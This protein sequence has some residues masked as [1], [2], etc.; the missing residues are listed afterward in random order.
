MKMMGPCG[1]LKVPRP[2]PL[3]LH[4][5]REPLKLEQPQHVFFI[6]FRR[7]NKLVIGDEDVEQKSLSNEIELIFRVVKIC[8]HLR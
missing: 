1:T 4:L 3:L 2:H 8:L 6:G 5:G 7:N